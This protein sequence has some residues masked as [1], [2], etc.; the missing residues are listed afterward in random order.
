MCKSHNPFN[1]GLYDDRTENQSHKFKEA[2]RELE[3]D[4][5]EARFDG[6]EDPCVRMPREVLAESPPTSGA[7]TIGVH[8]I[9]GGTG[10]NWL[11]VTFHN[12]SFGP[13][14]GANSVFDLATNTWSLVANTDIY[15]SGH[16]SMGNGTY[17]NAAGS[18][19]GRDSRGILLRNPDNVMNTSQYHFVSQPPVT[20]FGRIASSSDG[21]GVSRLNS[22][23]MT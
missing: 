23:A 16:S 8:S 6:S 12:A 21:S 14:G 7:A 17:A 4:D 13:A 9:S 1:T 5:D 18:Q 3:C 2:A 15:W 22:A 19:D 20:E 10:A 11:E